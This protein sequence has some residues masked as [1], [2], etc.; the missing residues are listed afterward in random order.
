MVSLAEI[1][2]RRGRLA[3]SHRGLAAWRETF[4][5]SLERP[6][7][8]VH[9]RKLSF[10]MRPSAGADRHP[11]RTDADPFS[12]LLNPGLDAIDQ[13]RIRI[14]FQVLA[15]PDKINP[16]GIVAAL[17]LVPD[18]SRFPETPQ[19]SA[20]R[21]FAHPKQRR[22]RRVRPT[23]LRPVRFNQLPSEIDRQFSHTIL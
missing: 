9:G 7:A 4:P 19:V 23:F 5:A 11:H 8:R 17:R 22:R 12:T 20:Y 18:I 3:S 1:L 16:S 10:F 2:I 15:Q 21:C 13:S 14:R 6:R